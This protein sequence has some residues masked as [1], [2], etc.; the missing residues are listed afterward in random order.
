MKK[1]NVEKIIKDQ[2]KYFAVVNE[3]I[4]K[5]LAQSLQAGGRMLVDSAGLAFVYILETEQEF[6]YVSFPQHTWEELHRVLQQSAIITLRLNETIH[7][8]LDSIAE[9]LSF[10]TENIEGNS[11][12]G[13]EMEKAVHEVF[14]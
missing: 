12:Y 9:E 5:E 14:N 10:L 3:T 4:D 1:L 11:N 2:E 6:F 8:E 13:E 7:I